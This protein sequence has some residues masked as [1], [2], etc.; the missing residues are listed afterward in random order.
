M[1][2]GCKDWKT[3]R[4]LALAG[5]PGGARA[6]APILRAL[7]ERGCKLVV[8]A[9]RQAVAVFAEEGVSCQLLD[10]PLSFANVQAL[11]ETHSPQLLLTAT[12][13][14]GLDFER[15]FWREARARAVPIFVQMD[16]WCNYRMRFE[17][18]AGMLENLPD[19]IGVMDTRAVREMVAEGFSL[20][21]LVITGQP[22]W[23]A[24]LQWP[25]EARR[26][27]RTRVRA[28]LGSDDGER[29]LVFVSQPLEAFHRETG[30][31]RPL[32][33]SEHRV[34]GEVLQ[35]LDLLRAEQPL[36]VLIR[37]HPRE[38]RAALEAH[39]A[40]YAGWVYVSDDGDRHDVCA[41][42]DV[43]LGMH[44]VLLFEAALTGVPVVS[45]QP[46]DDSEQVIEPGLKSF[47]RTATVRSPEQV[48]EVLRRL[49]A[50]D[51]DPLGELEVQPLPRSATDTVLSV[52]E[53][54]C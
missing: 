46:V 11:F 5:D 26:L 51:N 35:I 2:S 48:R 10:E 30:D 22:A 34:L 47:P 1:D 9:Y 15:L 16:F 12:S 23:D 3:V 25:I 38:K 7:Q 37:P 50:E 28:S 24:L 54:M 33:F 36:R 17:N 29:L 45:Y 52:L 4:V 44:S 53:Q 49:L 41:A 43:V 20:E 39:A 18:E 31:T 14:N 27:A 19:Q 21:R 13:C 42:A 8:F 40:A 6:I 32:L